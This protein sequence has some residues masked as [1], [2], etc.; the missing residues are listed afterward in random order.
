[1]RREHRAR[2]HLS[3]K[4]TF[5]KLRFRYAINLFISSHLIFKLGISSRRKIP[6][7]PGLKGFRE[8]IYVLII[9]RAQYPELLLNNNSKHTRIIGSSLPLELFLIKPINRV[10]RLDKNPRYSMPSR[11]FFPSLFPFPP[12]CK[13]FCRARDF[14]L[15]SRSTFLARRLSFRQ[16]AEREHGGLPH[17]RW[18][19]R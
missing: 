5:Y 6:I 19:H 9:R 7:K 10:R 18:N 4:N 16:R 11:V 12:R 15:F 14:S 17:P 1:M 3:L 8:G 13:P 2:F